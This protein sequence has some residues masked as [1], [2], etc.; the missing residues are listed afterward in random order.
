[1]M[2]N[3]RTTNVDRMAGMLKALGN[4]HR[5]R[6]YLTLVSCCPPGTECRIEEEAVPQCV[7]DLARELDLAPSTVSHHL[8]E[9]RTSGLLEM[10]RRGQRIECRASAE[11]YEELCGFFGGI[12]EGSGCRAATRKS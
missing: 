6:L 7:G 3:F 5:L 11:A 12:T 8:K 1:M 4:P 2:S 10:E 9:L